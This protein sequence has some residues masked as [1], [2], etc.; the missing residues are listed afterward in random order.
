MRIESRGGAEHP[1][2]SIARGEAAGDDLRCNRRGIWTRKVTLDV[3][4]PERMD[5]AAQHDRIAHRRRR[6]GRCHAVAG[7]A[8]AV[9]E[10]RIDSVWIGWQHDAGKERLLRDRKSTRLNSSP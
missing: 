7:R 1:L 3:V 9:P 8:I 10:V 2:R 5:V 4:H 6:Q